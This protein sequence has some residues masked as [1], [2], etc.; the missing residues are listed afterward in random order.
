MV[1]KGPFLGRR[2]HKEVDWGPEV[3]H[4]PCGTMFESGHF[5]SA[6]SNI[7]APRGEGWVVRLAGGTGGVRPLG[8]GHI[9][10]QFFLR[11]KIDAREGERRVVGLAGR[12]GRQ[13]RLV[14][15]TYDW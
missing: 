15:L 14:L 8:C 11:N 2:S 4:Q 7:V 13:R 12:T 1:E 5:F 10:A 9:G 6:D 3:G